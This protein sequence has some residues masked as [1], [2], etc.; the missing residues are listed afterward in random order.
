[1]QHAFVLKK[2]NF[3]LLNPYP[4]VLERGGGGGVVGSACKIF[5]TM[6]VHSCFPLI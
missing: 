1:M 3:D 5:A 2:V 4:R 6:L